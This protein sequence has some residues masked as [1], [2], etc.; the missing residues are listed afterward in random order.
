MEGPE[1]CM[2]TVPHSGTRYV[3]TGFER[4]GLV[5]SHTSRPVGIARD[6]PDLFWFHVSVEAWERTKDIPAKRFIVVRDPSMTWA[7]WMFNQLSAEDLDYHMGVKMTDLLNRYACQKYVLENDD[8]WHIHRVDKDSMADLSE[9]AGI[10]LPEHTNTY[11]R[12]MS[13]LK[14]AVEERDEDKIEEILQ[15]AGAWKRFK[16]KHEGYSGLYE[17]L[18]YDLWWL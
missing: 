4:T 16:R 3:L 12:G 6:Y 17:K 14:L 5:A 13:P 7:T 18:G 10:E 2:M 11:S 8:S 9:W 15:G 1:Y